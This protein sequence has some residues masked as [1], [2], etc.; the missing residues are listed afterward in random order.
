MIPLFPRVLMEN[1]GCSVAPRCKVRSLPR[2]QRFPS[3][4]TALR[5]SCFTS[6]KIDSVS[7]RP[8]KVGSR[9]TKTLDV[10]A[11]IT[12]Q[13]KKAEVIFV[14]KEGMIL[15]PKSLNVEDRREQQ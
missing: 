11:T 4:T 5:L 2:I 8:Q 3:A 13:S 7:F 14:A 6:V 9:W 15:L 12:K 10:T 1:L